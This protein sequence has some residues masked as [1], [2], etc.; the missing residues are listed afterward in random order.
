ME[1]IYDLVKDDTKLIHALL[2]GKYRDLGCDKDALYEYAYEVFNLSKEVV[3]TIKLKDDKQLAQWL[4]SNKI[5]RKVLPKKTIVKEDIEVF[6]L[7]P[8]Y[9]TSKLRDMIERVCKLLVDVEA[10]NKQ[11]EEDKKQIKIRRRN[12]NKKW[13]SKADNKEKHNIKCKEA[14]RRYREKKRLNKC[15]EYKVENGVVIK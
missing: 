15:V 5:N 10:K 2:D 13:L 11:Y 4:Y 6:D 9:D 14:M 7:E 12:H 3:D 1:S 8:D